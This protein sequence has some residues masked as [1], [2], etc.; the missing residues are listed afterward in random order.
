MAIRNAT[1]IR[2]ALRATTQEDLAAAMGVT[3]SRAR[4]SLRNVD[5]IASALAALGLSIDRVEGA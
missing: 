5:A 2:K 1:T 3:R 4:R